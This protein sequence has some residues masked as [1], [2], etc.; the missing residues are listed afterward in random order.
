MEALRVS[1]GVFSL[2][3]E[4]EAFQLSLLKIMATGFSQMPLP[5]R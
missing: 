2:I 1:F 3:L 5:G 4:E